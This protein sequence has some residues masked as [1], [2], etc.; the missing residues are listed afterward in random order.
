[1]AIADCVEASERIGRNTRPPDRQS[2]QCIERTTSAIGQHRLHHNRRASERA[3]D[4]HSVP[5]ESNGSQANRP[6]CPLVLPRMR[7]A[8]RKV[9]R[10]GRSHRPATTAN[11]R[12]LHRLARDFNHSKLGRLSLIGCRKGAHECGGRNRIQNPACAQPNELG[13]LDDR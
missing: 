11:R 5:V 9:W 6:L 1:M 10:S 2:L 8:H 7:F 4:L 3:A 12:D 13:A